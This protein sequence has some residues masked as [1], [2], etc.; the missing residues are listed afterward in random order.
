MRD[1][2]AIVIGSV[3][4]P[5]AGQSIATAILLEHLRAVGFEHA[6]VDLARAFHRGNRVVSYG[7]RALQVAGLPVQA[8]AA[9]RRLRTRPTVLYLQLGQSAEAMAR[10]LPVLGLAR[11]LGLPTVVHVHGASFRPAL[12]A[13]PWPLRRAVRAALQAVDRVIVLGDSLRA[14]FDGLVPP[15]RVVVVANGVQ[16][17]LAGFAAAEA[18][19]QRTD[20]ALT[21]LYLGNLIAAKG[22]AAVLEAGRLLHARGARHRVLVVGAHTETTD[23]DPER[24]IADHGLQQTV[25]YLGPVQGVEKLALLSGSDVLVLP[26]A[27]TEGQPISV[28]EA[29]HFGMPVITTHGGGLRDLVVDGEHGA[30]VPPRDAEAIVAAT[31][32]LTDPERFARISAT[33]RQQARARYSAAAHGEAVLG[34][35]ADAIDAR[36]SR[37]R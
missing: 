14:M 20:D 3:P 12:D 26:T 36:S 24:Y 11:G 25:S 10:D 23:I 7:R 21:L 8:L 28:L 4:P 13:A 29:M 35:M 9:H 30:V 22:Y 34:V 31:K 5:I 16:S 32:L 18:P 33:N 17:E 6:V 27:M 2:S 19:R 1:F 37:R 15:E